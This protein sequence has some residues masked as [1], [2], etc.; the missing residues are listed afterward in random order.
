MVRQPHG[1]SLMPDWISHEPVAW[2][3]AADAVIVCAIAFGA[4]ISVDQKTAISALVVALSMLF[5]RSK[6][7]P[8]AKIE[9]VPVAAQALKQAE[10]NT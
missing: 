9:A 4:P 5:A 7:V 3:V 6:V 1:E 2:T 8:V 10:A